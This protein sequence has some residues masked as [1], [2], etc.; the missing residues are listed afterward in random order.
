MESTLRSVFFAQ[1]VQSWQ[2][3]NEFVSVRTDRI[4]FEAVAGQIA[5]DTVGRAADTGTLLRPDRLK[6]SFL[7]PRFLEI[8]GHWI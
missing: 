6:S 5:D 1:R 2:D 7:I 8:A 4:L 3:R